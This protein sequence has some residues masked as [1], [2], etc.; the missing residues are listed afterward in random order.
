LTIVLALDLA[1]VTGWACGEPGST[2]AHGSIRFAAS[3][4]SH[5]A[6]FHN[7]M[8]WAERKMV[9]RKPDI[10]VWEAPLATSFKR[11]TST[12]NT[13]TILYGLPAVIGAVAYK[14]GVYDIRKAETKDVRHHFIGCNPKRA[15]AKPMV[16]ERCAALGAPLS[17]LSLLVG[18]CQCK[19]VPPRRM[20]ASAST[21]GGTSP[22]WSSSS[23]MAPTTRV[24]PR[25]ATAAMNAA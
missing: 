22:P 25:T 3:G 5:E 24:T 12:T 20:R 8:A 11:G 7:A 18:G 2:P 15:Q 16:I 4:A 17:M 1:T 10:V 6:I 23:V 13:T 19:L 21:S 9:F 14:H